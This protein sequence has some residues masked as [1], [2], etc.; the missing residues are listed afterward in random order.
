[1]DFE[2][3]TGW[4]GI[5]L[6]AISF[7]TAV[8]SPRL[9]SKVGGYRFQL[10]V[11]HWLGLTAVVSMIVHLGLLLS[12][13]SSSLDQLFDPLDGAIWAGW[14]ALICTMVAAIVAFRFR[15]V[16]YRRWR[17]IHLI[18]ILGF[19]AGIWHSF[20]IFEPR[21]ISE[22]GLIGIAALI[23]VF[24][25]AW[26]LLIPQSTFFGVHYAIVRQTMPRPNLFLQVLKPTNAAKA[27]SF[28]A[29]QFVFL[30]YSA[31]QFSRMWHPFT[32]IGFSSSGEFEL[33]IKA[34]GRDTNLLHEVQLPSPVKINGPFGVNFWHSNEPQLWLAY[35][36][37]VAIFLAAARMMPDEFDAE[38]HL[39]YC[40]KNRERLVFSAEFDTLSVSRRNFSWDQY[41]GEGREVLADL[42]ENMEKCSRKYKLFRICGHPGFQAAAKDLLIAKGV[43]K[44][45]IVLEG[46]F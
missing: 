13:Y 20:R 5:F 40:D 1:M 18:L 36:I 27:I 6:L 10:K 15:S 37:G 28:R 3:F 45:A 42:E 8:R 32:V 16:P 31:P 21:T 9:S 23:G 34:R 12:D 46:V 43:H 38:V 41:Y 2:R 24:G 14:I 26:T 7:F 4:I 35:G 29:G 17:R 22:W 19:F 25:I 44:S 39:T 30:Q 11:H 33:L